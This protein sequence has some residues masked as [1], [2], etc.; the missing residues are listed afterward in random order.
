MRLEKEKEERR[1]KEEHDLYMSQKEAKEA[2]KKEKE[3][4]AQIKKE[5]AARKKEWAP[6][7]PHPRAT[8]VL[9]GVCRPCQSLTRLRV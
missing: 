7:F 6:L 5:A 2:L 1:K 8:L 9:A 3:L 4:E